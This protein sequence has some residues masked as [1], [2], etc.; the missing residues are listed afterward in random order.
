MSDLR[1]MACKLIGECMRGGKDTTDIVAEYLKRTMAEGYQ[2]RAAQHLAA[3]CKWRAD[4]DCI[5]TECGQSLAFEEGWP[6]DT[7]P[8]CPAC[9][10]RWE[11]VAKAKMQCGE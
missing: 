7:M 6:N 9:G 11:R 2:E 5:D 10:R 4:E 3:R 8:F 1:E